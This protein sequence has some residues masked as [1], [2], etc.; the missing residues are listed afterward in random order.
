MRGNRN[1]DMENNELE[2]MIEPEDPERKIDL[3]RNRLFL[4]ANLSLLEGEMF[5]WVL[6]QVSFRC[7][8]AAVSA[9]HLDHS[10]DWTYR[11]YVR[12]FLLLAFVFNV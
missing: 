9:A 12:I 3:R 4:F 11:N 6:S 8:L 10:H 5:L 2:T 7:C 1:K